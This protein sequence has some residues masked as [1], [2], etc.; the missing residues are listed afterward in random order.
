[1]L[2]LQTRPHLSFLSHFNTLLW[3]VPLS[4]LLQTPVPEEHFWGEVYSFWGVVG[5]VCEGFGDAAAYFVIHGY[6]GDLALE[7]GWVLLLDDSDGVVG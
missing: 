3:L 6:S 5:G 4:W 2:H 7:V 1:M